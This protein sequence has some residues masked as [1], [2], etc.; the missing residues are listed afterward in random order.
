MEIEPEDLYDEAIEIAK[1][2]EIDQDKYPFEISLRS[3][4]VNFTTF[5]KESYVEKCSLSTI[6]DH[7]NSMDIFGKALETYGLGNNYRILVTDF[8]WSE[9]DICFDYNL[10]NIKT[11]EFEQHC[12]D[13]AE[14]F[15]KMLNN[16]ELP[17]EKIDGIPTIDETQTY[18][19][20]SKGQLKETVTSLINDK[21]NAMIMV[22]SLD[23]ASE[24][25]LSLS[26]SPYEAEMRFNIRRT[27]DENK[28]FGKRIPELASSL[29]DIGVDFSGDYIIEEKM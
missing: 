3:E 18:T 24:L 4:N 28:T 21:P 2:V 7:Y 19:A 25:G 1:A 22:F 6:V 29:I 15:E 12:G 8:S 11:K 9:S 5:I 23:K 13:K 14:I 10:G 26:Y 17:Y 27:I 20:P 16:L